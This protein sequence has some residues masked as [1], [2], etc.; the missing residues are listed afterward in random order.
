MKPYH[1]EVAKVGPSVRAFLDRTFPD[2]T[3]DKG[4]FDIEKLRTGSVMVAC[5]HRS[6]MDYFL[7]ALLM[8]ELGLPNVRGAAGDNLMDLPYIG[9]K[10]RDWGAFPVERGKAFERAYVQNLCNEVVRMLAD[11]D[12]ILVF[13]EGARSYDGHMMDIKAGVLG[14][15]V[16]NQAQ[17]PD[18]PTFIVPVAVSY[19]TVPEVA[20]F[21][22]LLKGKVLRSN[23][24]AG[25]LTR[26]RGALYYYGADLIAFSKLFFIPRFVEP[27]GTLCIDI[28]QPVAVSN[29]VKIEPVASPASRHGLS[30]YREAIQSVAGYVQR[31][32][33]ALLRVLPLSVVAA[34][35]AEQN[36][37]TPDV[38]ASHVDPIR[39]RLQADG[40]NCKTIAPMSDDELVAEGLRQLRH[41]AAIASRG[42]PVRV[43]NEM[44]LRYYAASVRDMPS[45]IAASSD[46]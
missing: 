14:A 36:A 10:F 20:Y 11:S 7:I 4:Q 13:P 27:L 21:G 12:S 42:G 26:A 38:I 28:G 2:T 19:A 37:D 16:I 29:I 33:N 44:I 23:K 43:V 17:R 5:T 46:E 45:D 9:K 3:V 40:R 30:L 1:R 6:H 24:N 22:R 39:R 35:I 18:K 15:S 32:F 25:F 31:Q 34:I 41:N 8:H